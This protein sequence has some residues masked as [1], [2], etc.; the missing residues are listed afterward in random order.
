[1]TTQ[2]IQGVQLIAHF[3]LE[4]PEN[5]L[6]SLVLLEF[7]LELELD[8]VDRVPEHWNRQITVFFLQFLQGRKQL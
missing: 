7:V 3:L 5:R 6:H 1:M 2:Y 4:L 8:G